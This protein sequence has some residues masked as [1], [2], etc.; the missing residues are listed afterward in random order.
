MALMILRSSQQI[1]GGLP[2]DVKLRM[3]FN[4][5]LDFGIG[6]VPFIGDLADGECHKDHHAREQIL[7]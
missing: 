7:H 3:V 6:L 2:S 1:E 5:I 4:I